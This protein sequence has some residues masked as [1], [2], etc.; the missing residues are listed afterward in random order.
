VETTARVRRNAAVWAAFLSV[1]VAAWIATVTGG[2]VAM[3]AVSLPLFLAMWLVMMIAMMFPAVAPIAIAWSGSI[4][5]SSTRLERAFRISTFVAGYLA[6]WSACG[7]LAFGVLF[8]L[9]AI[10]AQLPESVRPMDA[11]LFVFAGLYQLTPLK[12]MC[13]RHCRSPLM[14]LLQHAGVRGRLRDVRVGVH[15]GLFCIG[16][17]WGLMVVLI[18]VGIMNVGAMALLAAAI[19]LEK[20]WRRGEALAKALGVLFLVLAVL[21]ATD[22]SLVPGLAP[23]AQNVPAMPPMRM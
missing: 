14:F 8:A 9:G 2:A 19:C 22:P 15:H 12:R 5:P 16:C 23:P 20:L 1:S 10:E 3:S 21:I 11:A 17:C 13:L 4:A 7:T 18:A 6:A